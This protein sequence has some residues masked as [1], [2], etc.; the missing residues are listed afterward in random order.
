MLQEFVVKAKRRVKEKDTIAI[1]IFRNVVK[2]KSDNKP[3]SYDSYQYEEYMKLVT[4]LYNASDKLLKRKILKPFRLITQ[5]QDTTEMPPI[6]P[7]EEEL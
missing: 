6:N 7:D 1:R 2:H 3:K 5:N 4:S